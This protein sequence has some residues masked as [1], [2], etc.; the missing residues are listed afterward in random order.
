MG[1]HPAIAEF[2][3]RMGD[4]FER[5]GLPPIGGRIF[6]WLLV[7]DPEEQDAAQISAAVEASAGS[8][9]TMARM[10]IRWPT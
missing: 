8:V 3:A 4:F 6:G 1:E 5:I 10:L 2:T 7:C 9:N